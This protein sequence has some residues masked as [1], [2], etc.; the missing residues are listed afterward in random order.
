L[1]DLPKGKDLFFPEDQE[2]MGYFRNYFNREEIDYM[3]FCSGIPLPMPDNILT[4]ILASEPHFMSD[5]VITI[6][7]NDGNLAVIGIKYKNCKTETQKIVALN[8][9]LN[10]LKYDLGVKNTPGLIDDN[11]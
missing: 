1:G 10:R 4:T 6:P 3:G 8:D 5:F 7:L 11:D 2:I 9:Y